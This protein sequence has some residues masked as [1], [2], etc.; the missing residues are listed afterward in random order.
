LLVDVDDLCSEDRV[1]DGLRVSLEVIAQILYALSAEVLKHFPSTGKVLF[2]EC[3]SRSVENRAGTKFALP[4]CL[5]SLLA[6]DTSVS[7]YNDAD[8]G[9]MTLGGG[10]LRRRS[11]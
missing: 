7:A 1:L 10:L 9:A 6:V 5:L 11:H 3:H 4:K 8:V 2:P